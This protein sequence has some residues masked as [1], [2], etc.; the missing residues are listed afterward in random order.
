MI[1]NV[2][3][4]FSISHFVLEL[5]KFDVNETTSDVRLCTDHLKLLENHAHASLRLI[6]N[7][8]PCDIQRVHTHLICNVLSDLIN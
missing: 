1:K 5:F 2:F 3:Y 4:S 7:T 8:W 6:N